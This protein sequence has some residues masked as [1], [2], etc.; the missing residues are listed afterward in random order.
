M[1]HLHQKHFF[2]ICTIKVCHTIP[3]AVIGIGMCRPPEESMFWVTQLGF[4][5]KKKFI[6]IC[7]IVA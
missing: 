4:E 6:S 7:V 2:I 1:H 5:K 3:G